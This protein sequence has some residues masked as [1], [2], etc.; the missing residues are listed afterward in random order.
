MAEWGIDT[1]VERGGLQ[2][3]EG[4]DAQQEEGERRKVYL[5][6]RKGGKFGAGLGKTT[7]WIHRSALARRDVTTMGKCKYVEV[8]DEGLVVERDEKR[9]VLEVDTVVICAGQDP[10]RTLLKQL[11]ADGKK[12]PKVFLIGGSEEASELDAKRAIDQG[13]RYLFIAHFNCCLFYLR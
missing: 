6:Q 13:T 7:G 10:E 4:G 11:S 8:T 12:K 3:H 9:E 5:L 1:S 2:L